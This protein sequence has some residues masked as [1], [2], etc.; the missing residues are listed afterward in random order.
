MLNFLFLLDLAKPCFQPRPTLIVWC[1]NLKNVNSIGLDWKWSTLMISNAFGWY[2]AFWWHIMH[3]ALTWTMSSFR[4]GYQNVSFALVTIALME[5]LGDLNVM[6]SVLQPSVPMV[7][8]TW[9]HCTKLIHYHWRSNYLYDNC[10]LTTL[11]HRQSV[12]YW[13]T[14]ASSICTTYQIGFLLATSAK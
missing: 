7:P 5:P 14:S 8:K 11:Q 9:I 12:L 13:P 10:I 3:V 6:L 1:I 2:G 4:T